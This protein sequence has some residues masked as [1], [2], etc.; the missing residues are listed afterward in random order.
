VLTVHHRQGSA[1]IW[2]KETQYDA[3]YDTRAP[4]GGLAYLSDADEYG[5]EHEWWVVIAATDTLDPTAAQE[6]PSD[7]QSH[8]SDVRIFSWSRKGDQPDRKP[9]RK[10]E[11]P[12]P[13]L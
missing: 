13:E 4:P 11:K 6:P 5:L 12:T 10:P 2:T 3:S 8:R 1:H 9:T 7:E